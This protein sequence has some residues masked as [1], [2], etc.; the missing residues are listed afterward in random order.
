MAERFDCYVSLGDS[1]SI[2]DYPGP[3]LGAASLL[4]RNADHEFPEFKG[5]DL[6]S[7]F[8][9][10]SF[11]HLARDGATTREVQDSLA[12]LPPQP[13]RVLFSLTVGGN[14]LLRGR[15]RDLRGAIATYRENLERILERILRDYAGRCRVVQA[16][17][18]DPTDGVGDLMAKGTPNPGLVAF[19]TSA[20][21]VI[22]ELASG[23][24][25]VSVADVHAHFLG[26]GSHASEGGNPHYSPADPSHWIKLGIEPNERGG[27]EVRRV[28]WDTL[29]EVE[30][31]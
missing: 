29:S 18:Y 5:R 20:N 3:G 13:G 11:T 2:D 27:S 25:A 7:R 16:L 30:G 1:M 4:Y 23:R 28:L 14:D 9:G 8:P 15:L 6:A 24:P 21:A 10:I 31:W 19:L 22:T 26:H 17:I 12:S